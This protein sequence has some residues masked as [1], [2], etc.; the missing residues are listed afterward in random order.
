[1][2]GHPASRTEGGC[3]MPSFDLREN[4]YFALR[5]HRSGSWV[6]GGLAVFYLSLWAVYQ[7]KLV[8]QMASVVSHGALA[9]AFFDAIFEIFVPVTAIWLLYYFFVRLGLG[10]VGMEVDPRGFS[11]HFASG[12]SLRIQYSDPSFNVLIKDIS[13]FPRSFP[14]VRFQLI[15]PWRTVPYAY[16]PESA[17]HELLNAAR[18]GGLATRTSSGLNRHAN[19]LSARYIRIHCP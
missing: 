15:L 1:M 12:K 6:F 17:L 16:I 2:S 8:N 11:L 9:Q 5:L 10:P 7:P 19:A 4:A 18:H 14:Q 13:A 3:E